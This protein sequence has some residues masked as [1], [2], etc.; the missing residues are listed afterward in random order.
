MTDVEDSGTPAPEQPA[1]VPDPPADVTDPPAQI[2]GFMRLLTVI[3][4]PT[5]V[6]ADIARKPSFVA[7]VLLSALIVAGSGVLL[8]SRVTDMG[9]AVRD[10][11]E[12]QG[13]MSP[14]EIETAVEWTEK[15]AW[16]NPVVSFVF[17][18]LGMALVALVFF[19]GLKLAGAKAGVGATFSATFHAYWPPLLIKSLLASVIVLVKG[20][21]TV[22]QLVSLVK[23]NPVFLLSEDAS[24]TL[25][26]LL[27][28][29]DAFN[30][31]TLAL[32]TIGLATVGKIPVARAFFVVA[33]PWVLF[34]V[35]KV[36]WAALFG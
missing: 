19:L 1:D 3:W 2:S 30:A 9:D 22:D 16:V 15:L 18:P 36:G 24:P 25:I 29:L 35:L 11:L 10:K 27:S 20:E 8:M 13:Q 5:A 7:V 32:V 23:S 17:Y 21:V 6:F 26:S 34:I 28:T 33:V 31:W 4:S 14:E 12:E